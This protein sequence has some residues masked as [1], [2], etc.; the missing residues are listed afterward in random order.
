MQWH[1][2]WGFV[3]QASEIDEILAGGKILYQVHALKESTIEWHGR[4][5]R[6][7]AEHERVVAVSAG[8]DI[9]AATTGQDV[10]S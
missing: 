9:V 4:A 10:I 5:V 8:Q 3:G 6:L 1:V 2:T 7:V